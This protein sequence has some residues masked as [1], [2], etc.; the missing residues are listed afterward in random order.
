MVSIHF[1]GFHGRPLGRVLN[2]N[3]SRCAIV[4][5]QVGSPNWWPL[6]TARR[7]PAHSR[8]VS[9]RWTK[10][11]QDADGWRISAIDPA[12]AIPQAERFG[13]PAD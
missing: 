1:I 4:S 9:G 11:R 6:T 5:F 12:V 10:D 13:T 2:S 7:T 8:A 3:P